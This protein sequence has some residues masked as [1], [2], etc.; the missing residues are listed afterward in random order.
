MLFKNVTHRLSHPLYLKLIRQLQPH[1]E[2]LSGNALAQLTGVSRPKANQA[3]RFLV[4]QGILSQR[5]AGKSFL[6]RICAGHI[7][8]EQILLPLLEFQKNIY[9]DLGQF[10]AKHLKPR[11][12]SIILYGSFARGEEDPDSDIDIV[13]VYE[14][15]AKAPPLNTYDQT[16]AAVNRRY[17]NRLSIRR[18]CKNQLL[19][20]YKSGDPLILNIVHEGLL[21]HGKPFL[22]EIKHGKNS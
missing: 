4:N 13:L 8:L 20:G 15:N 18:A 12:T 11:P 14:K 5:S 6:Y 16:I 17:G 19:Q 10:I 7:L 2:G 9:V 21:I 3:L 22:Q 1:V